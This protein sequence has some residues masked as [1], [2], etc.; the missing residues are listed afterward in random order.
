MVA[1]GVFKL[2]MRRPGGQ[3]S[4]GGSIGMILGGSALLVVTT[5]ANISSETLLEGDAQEGLDALDGFDN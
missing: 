2:I 4:I 1:F 5:I 3:D